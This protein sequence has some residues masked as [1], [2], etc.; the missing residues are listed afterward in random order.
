M[1]PPLAPPV[2]GGGHAMTSVRVIHEEDTAQGW[3]HQ[4]EI[5]PDQG[6]IALV[7]V[8]LSFQDY[9]YW[10]GGTR[11]PEQVTVSLIECLLDPGEDASVPT[12]LPGQFDASTARRWMP[13]LDACI[14]SGSWH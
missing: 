6:Q 1:L 9:E 11:P 5:K 3:S 8:Q 10:S 13:G 12:P 4:V 14:R 2:A 7:M